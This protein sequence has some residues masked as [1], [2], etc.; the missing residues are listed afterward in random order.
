MVQSK[1]AGWHLNAF[2]AVTR[3]VMVVTIQSHEFL[4][5]YEETFWFNLD[6]GLSRFGVRRLCYGPTR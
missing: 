6:A 1:E 3:L 2:C 4:E 5:K